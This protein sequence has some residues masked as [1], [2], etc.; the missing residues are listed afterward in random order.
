MRS[1]DTR[2]FKLLRSRDDDRSRPI[3]CETLALERTGDAVSHFGR[4]GR[5]SR[6][7]MP[8]EAGHRPGKMLGTATVIFRTG[9]HW[10]TAA[11]DLGGSPR[12]SGPDGVRTRRFAQPAWHDRRP[13]TPGRGNRTAPLCIR[14][15]ETRKLPARVW[16]GATSPELAGGQGDRVNRRS[17][18]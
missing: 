11:K 8:P 17:C 5:P 16:P 6:G 4:P 13:G 15:A 14:C 18:L 7:L 1:L 12:P 2:Q 9:S 3:R 10:R